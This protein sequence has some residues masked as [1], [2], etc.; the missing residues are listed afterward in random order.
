VILGPGKKKKDDI[1][2]SLFKAARDAGQS[3]YFLSFSGSEF[4]NLFDLV[5]K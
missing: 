2:G 3:D 4:I 5:E 1:V